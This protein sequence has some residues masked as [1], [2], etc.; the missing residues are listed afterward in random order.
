MSKELKF[1]LQFNEAYARAC[2]HKRKRIRKK[3][4]HRAQRMMFHT[5]V[6]RWGCCPI[7]PEWMIERAE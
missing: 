3:N 2:F 6:R 5:A 7:P 1:C 4:Y